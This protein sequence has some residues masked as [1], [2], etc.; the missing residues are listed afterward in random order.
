[1]PAALAQRC[2]AAGC[3]LG[4][5]VLDPFSGSGTTEL[6][7]ARLGRRYVG[8]DLSAEYLELSLRTRLGRAAYS[9]CNVT[10]VNLLRLVVSDAILSGDAR[11][12][13]L[14][15]GPI[16]DTSPRR[17]IDL[18]RWGRAT[19]TGAA[20]ADTGCGHRPARIREDD[21]LSQTRAD[22]RLSGDLPR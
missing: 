5:T 17:N 15:F 16:L 1:M 19:V 4:G 7:A 14:A 9:G 2:V 12:E 22:D 3:K 6:A 20:A 11:A 8:I 21:A 13:Q 10:A 18:G